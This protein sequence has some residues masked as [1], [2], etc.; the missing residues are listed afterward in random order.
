MKSLEKIE[1][2]CSDEF[3]DITT[4]PMGPDLAG[5]EVKRAI[6]SR[7][8]DEIVVVMKKR[9]LDKRVPIYQTSIYIPKKDFKKK[10]DSYHGRYVDLIWK[11]WVLGL[12]N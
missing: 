8:P 5:E 11:T 6:L 4:C 10:S 12:E 7:N 3:T 2:I 9:D 1:Q